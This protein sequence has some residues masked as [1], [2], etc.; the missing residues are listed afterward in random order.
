[1]KSIDDMILSDT[2]HL[3]NAFDIRY[4]VYYGL[5]LLKRMDGERNS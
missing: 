5:E 2:L 3:I 1:M 4:M